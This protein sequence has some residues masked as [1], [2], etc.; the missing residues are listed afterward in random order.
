MRR[1]RTTYKLWAPVY[2]KVM[3]PFAGQARQHAIELLK[4]Q[5]GESVLLVGRGHRP[6]FAASSSGCEGHWN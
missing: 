1:N 6:G 5:P 3:G 2:D 4:L